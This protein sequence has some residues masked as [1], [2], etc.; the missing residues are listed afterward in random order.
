MMALPLVVYNDA[1][2]PYKSLQ[3]EAWGAALV[4]VVLVLIINLGS[5]FVLRRQIRLAGK[6]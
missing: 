2:T 4:L 3:Q 1:R 5:R 6:I